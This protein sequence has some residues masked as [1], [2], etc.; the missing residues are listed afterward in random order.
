MKRF[1]VDEEAAGTG[2]HPCQGRKKVNAPA[3]SR[4][5][6]CVRLIKH[7]RGARQ[8]SGLL[9]ST[10]SDSPVENI[11]TQTDQG[12]MGLISG[13]RTLRFMVIPAT[14]LLLRV[15]YYLLVLRNCA[16]GMT[17]VSYFT[18]DVRLKAINHRLI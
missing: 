17:S 7:G 5:R 4:M 10:D 11:G 18:A 3:T 16:A 8:S 15:N 6:E 1:R 12:E 9:D 14:S 13:T 2:S